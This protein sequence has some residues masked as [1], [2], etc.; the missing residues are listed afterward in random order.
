MWGPFRKREKKKKS[1]VLPRAGR[2]KRQW[3][4]GLSGQRFWKG[5]E[6][7]EWRRNLNRETIKKG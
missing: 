1:T 5:S 4:E 7:E 6:K 3:G 2:V